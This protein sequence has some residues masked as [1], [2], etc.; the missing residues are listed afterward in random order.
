MVHGKREWLARR[1]ADICI[2][3]SRRSVRCKLLF[4]D[5]ASRV[6]LW[7]KA[8]LSDERLPDAVD[9]GRMDA[10]NAAAENYFERVTDPEYLLHKPFSDR[11]HFA[12][13]LFD[14]GVLLYWMRIR[15]GH[16]VAEIGAGSCW[17][18]HMLNR[19]GCR[20]L[21]VDV[22][23][24]VLGLGRTLFERDPATRWEL[25]PEF[26]EYDG[27]RLP[28]D[29]NSVDRI[30][31]YDAFHH[32]PNPGEILAEMHRVLRF[33]GIVGMREPGPAHSTSEKSLAETRDHGVL[34]SFVDPRTIDRVAQEVGFSRGTV[35]PITLDRSLEVPIPELAEFMRGKYLR[36]YWE[37]L[38][39]DL[40][41]HS[42]LLLYKGAGTPDSRAPEIL[43][44]EI[45]PTKEIE[46]LVLR[47][48]E[49]GRLRVRVGNTG[50]TI[51][52]A[53]IPGQSGWV[54]LGLSLHT[55]DAEA[56]LLE[57]DWH[58]GVLPHDVE[59][60]GEALVD[61]ELPPLAEP[62][63]YRVVVDLVAEEIAW[64]ADLGTEPA[65]VSVTTRT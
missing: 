61:L 22:S 33:G 9:P 17:L 53:D 59:P 38:S 37:R 64:F 21:A 28:M 58:R 44:A 54:R 56:S 49:P 25:Q 39:E 13:R 40:R 1:I 32:V 12:R 60:G 31:V 16:V 45:E 3:L 29:D 57:R 10:Y 24:T 41:D 36:A 26:L 42:F 2:G 19:F 18:S 20:T 5:V 65:V 62:G 63:E 46:P 30:V 8:E 35:V 15:P 4:A 51:W 23:T 55:A 27:R 52:L 47:V 50:D 7:D 6:F 11:V 14:V 48:G 34:E 43:A